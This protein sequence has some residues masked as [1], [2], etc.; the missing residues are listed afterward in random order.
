[1]LLIGGVFVRV[2]ATFPVWRSN[3]RI[4]K[5][6]IT[7]YGEADEY[8]VCKDKNNKDLLAILP[9]ECYA[10]AESHTIICD[11]GIDKHK[12]TGCLACQIGITKSHDGV[13]QLGIPSNE[14]YYTYDKL[15]GSFFKGIYTCYPSTNT[16]ARPILTRFNNYTGE[17]DERNFTNPLI[18]CYLWSISGGNA[19]VSCSPSHELSLDVPIFRGERE[20]HLDVTLRSAFGGEKFLFVVEGKRNVG[21]FLNDSKRE[22]KKKYEK[23]IT[24]I[25]T[26]LGYN[27]LFAYV[28]GGTEEA[29]YPPRTS[30]KAAAVLNRRK[31]FNDILKEEK[32]F[33]SMHA[34]RGLGVLYI[35]SEGYMCLE[36]TLFPLFKNDN[37]YGLVLGGAIVFNGEEFFLDDLFK[38]IP[39]H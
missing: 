23:G 12:C 28:I 25:G 21:T 4:F 9:K 3:S 8:L 39:I 30:Q 34:L 10:D 20:G 1:M 33:I 18:G 15:A 36:N 27:T 17:W 29:M 19:Y 13:N 11:D 32:R 38:Y 24:D 16:I 31:F 6:N 22:Q 37:V 2:R 26:D 35:A 7:R 14:V 5:E